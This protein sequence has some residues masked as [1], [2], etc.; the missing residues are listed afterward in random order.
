MNLVAGIDIPTPASTKGFVRSLRVRDWISSSLPSSNRSRSVGF[1][2]PVLLEFFCF[3]CNEPFTRSDANAAK[4]L[5][6][7]FADALGL[8]SNMEKSFVSALDCDDQILNEISQVLNC[9]IVQLPISYLGLSLHVRKARKSDF[10]ALIEKI[11]NWLAS[12]K[13]DM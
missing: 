4:Q 11:K 13:T 2:L 3:L 6:N 5:L 8:V 10:R 12:W 7:I 9:S 1:L